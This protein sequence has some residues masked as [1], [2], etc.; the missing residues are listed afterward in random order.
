MCVC[1][2]RRKLNFVVEVF[3]FGFGYP[4]SEF[5]SPEIT[6]SVN[7]MKIDTSNAVVII[8]QLCLKLIVELDKKYY[9]DLTRDLLEIIIG[10]AKRKININD[11]ITPPSLFVRIE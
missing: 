1:V 4:R 6:R 9:S 11:A 5:V 7:K 2:V 3:G 8:R 10:L